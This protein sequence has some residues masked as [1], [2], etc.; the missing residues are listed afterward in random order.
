MMIIQQTLAICGCYI[1]ESPIN[2]KT[3]NV[4]LMPYGKN[5]VSKLKAHE[6]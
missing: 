6:T 3:A 5:G 1:L 4:K 2:I